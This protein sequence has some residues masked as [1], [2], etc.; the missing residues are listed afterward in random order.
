MPEGIDEMID[1]ALWDVRHGVWFSGPYRL[2]YSV[3]KGDWCLWYCTTVM[4]DG[5]AGNSVI[6]KRGFDT[7][8]QAKKSVEGHRELMRIRFEEKQVA[9]KI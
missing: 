1:E 4:G 2:W 6:L 9:A 5:S 3:E 8:A 7:A